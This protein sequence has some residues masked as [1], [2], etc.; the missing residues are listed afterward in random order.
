[1]PKSFIA[2]EIIPVFSI[3]RQRRQHYDTYILTDQVAQARLE[4]VPERGGLVTSWQVQ[5]RE[6]LYMD[7]E[8]FA[9][10]NLT[11]RGGMPILFPICGSLLGNTFTHNGCD[12]TLTEHG[13]ARAQPW[14][15]IDRIT[16]DRVSIVLELWSNDQTRAVYP[17]DFQL[18]FT[19]TLQ[20]DTLATHQRYTNYSP[21][22]MPF[23]TGFHPYFLVID[24]AQLRFDI[25]AT[26]AIDHKTQAIQS[27]ANAF[28]FSSSEI[29]WAFP[30][31]TRP[32]ASVADRNRHTRITL[33]YSNAFSTLVFWTLQGKDFYCLEPWSAGQNALNSGD[34]LIYLA[35]GASLE[36]SMNLTVEFG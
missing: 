1:M 33:H 23:A 16:Q 34:R 8:R 35:P 21:E 30:Q 31:L 3:F 36:T 26:V 15:V 32:F 27:F 18:T 20:G 5:G 7:T 2:S 17:F 19:Y 28:D 11:V 9:N 10:P 12:Y 24:K 29:D 4:V 13:F 25:P 22:P 14:E 6:L